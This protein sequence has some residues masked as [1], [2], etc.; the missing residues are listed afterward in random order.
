MG[1]MTLLEN[2]YPYRRSEGGFE[3]RK[4]P[5]FTSLSRDI[6]G[7]GSISAGKK[8]A[9][10]GD[11]L[12]MTDGQYLYSWSAQL[13]KWIKRGK[14]GSVAANV[15]LVDG[16]VGQSQVNVDVAYANGYLIFVTSTSSAAANASLV[17]YVVEV[18]TGNLVHQSR[19]PFVAPT[20][21]SGQLARIV[22]VG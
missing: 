14:A 12:V 5:G 20:G 3:I 8:L 1:R 11:E 21:V 17:Y 18:S 9:F 13:S 15:E 6:Q 19:F 22:A 2:A 7:G 4:A 10:F 16:N